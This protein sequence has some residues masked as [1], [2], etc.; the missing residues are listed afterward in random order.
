MPS[1]SLFSRFLKK[2]KYCHLCLKIGIAWQ[3]ERLTF[4]K[5][6]EFYEELLLLLKVVTFRKVMTFIKTFYFY[7]WLKHWWKVVTIPVRHNKHLFTLYFVVYNVPFHFKTTKILNF[8]FLCTIK[9]LI[10][11]FFFLF[12]CTI[13]YLCTF[14]MLSGSLTLF[15]FVSLH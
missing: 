4:I 12:F 8:F 3:L 1:E 15:F 14:L 6:C 9:Y 13:K 2:L 11:N 10:L 5:S 7:G